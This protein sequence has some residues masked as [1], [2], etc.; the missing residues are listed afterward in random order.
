MASHNPAVR[1]AYYSEVSQAHVRWPLVGL[2]FQHEP[3]VI[4]V[5]AR[6]SALAGAVAVARTGA[7]IRLSD[8]DAGNCDAARPPHL[9]N[10]EHP[11]DTAEN[12]RIDQPSVSGRMT[13]S[14]VLSLDGCVAWKNGEDTG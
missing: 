10:G 12:R 14:I 11:I 4:Y 8:L 3:R 6:A 5:V 2:I 7:S 13:T 9:Q 1:G